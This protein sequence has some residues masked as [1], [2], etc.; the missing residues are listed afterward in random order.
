M[1]RRNQPNWTFGNSLSESSAEVRPNR[2]RLIPNLYYLLMQKFVK[3]KIFFFENQDFLLKLLGNGRKF[4]SARV[5]PNFCLCRKL[6]CLLFVR[7][8]GRTSAEPKVWPITNW[9]CVCYLKREQFNENG[10]LLGNSETLVNYY[11]NNSVNTVYLDESLARDVMVMIFMW[12][13]CKDINFSA[14]ISWA[15]HTSMS[16]N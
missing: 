5:R 16:H 11:K 2:T 9:L 3:K 1:H 6:L 10:S 15:N 13:C 7:K 4:G 8:F 14:L 12:Y